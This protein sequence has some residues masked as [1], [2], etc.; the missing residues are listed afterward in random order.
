MNKYVGCLHLSHAVVFPNLVPLHYFRFGYLTSKMYFNRP[1]NLNE[2]QNSVRTEINFKVVGE[3]YN[4]LGLC[5]TKQL[6]EFYNCAALEKNYF[7]KL[8]VQNQS[9]QFICPPVN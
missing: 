5:P 1:V 2:L 4:V 8:Q 3:P 9:Y 7:R 6:G